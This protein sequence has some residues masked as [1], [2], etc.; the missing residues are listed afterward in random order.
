MEYP[1][2]SKIMKVIKMRKYLLLILFILTS[3]GMVYGQQHGDA[4]LL[5]VG[6]HT[7]NRI[8]ISFH[9]DGQIAGIITGVDIR[10]E[11]PFGSGENYI[12][13]CI[14]IIGVEFVNTL[15]D[16]LHSVV[17]SRGP[18]NRQTDEKHPKYSYFW[19]WNPIPGFRNAGYESVAMSHLLDSYPPEGWNDPVAKGWK[20]E[21]GKTQ[22]FGYFGRDI[23]NADQESIFDADDQSDDEFNFRNLDPADPIFLPDANDPSRHGMALRMRVRGFQWSNFLAEDAIFWLYDIVNEGTTIYSKADF[24]TVVGT[25]AG[26]DGDSRDDLGYFD[27]DEWITYSW[28]SRRNW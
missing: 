17:I 26:G 2:T 10:G 3:A 23:K 28:D 11:W 9:N 13:D 12:G 22:W 7:G 24:G 14:P 4:L 1:I 6:L 15:G 27:V 8:G 18:R 21:R 19:G 20:D 25:L 5:S 16:T